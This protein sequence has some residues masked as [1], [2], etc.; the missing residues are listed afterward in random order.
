[1]KSLVI[2][3]IVLAAALAAIAP[4]GLNWAP[5]VFRFLRGSVPVLAILAAAVLIFVGIM[6]I[7]DH[8]D[9]KKE[10]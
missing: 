5:D 6:D 3:L 10:E 1:M 9:A 2:G 4:S 8:R 7:K